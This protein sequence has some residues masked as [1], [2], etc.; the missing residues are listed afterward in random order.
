M[1]LK[2]SL[3]LRDERL[4]GFF[5][6]LF[7]TFF[8]KP[9]GFMIDMVT[10]DRCR[11]FHNQTSSTPI[12]GGWEAQLIHQGI[13]KSRWLWNRTWSFRTKVPSLQTIDSYL[14]GIDSWSQLAVRNIL[15]YSVLIKGVYAFEGNS[16][17]RGPFPSGYKD[18]RIKQN[19]WSRP[20]VVGG[21]STRSIAW[22]KG[23]DTFPNFWQQKERII[24]LK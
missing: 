1:R 18:R 5:F 24:F 11:S 22:L 9:Y 23:L 6:I 10:I 13:E 15:S 8:N 12:H 7:L 16:E 3:A 20:L 17:G 21:C 19:A 14:N 2:A 4:N